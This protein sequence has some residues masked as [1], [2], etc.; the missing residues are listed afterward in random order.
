[1][2]VSAV[3]VRLLA[4]E[5]AWILIYTIPG[6][7]I[8]VSCFAVLLFKENPLPPDFK[9]VSLRTYVSVMKQNSVLICM[10]FQILSGAAIAILTIAYTFFGNRVRV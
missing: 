2:G 7:I 6:L 10:F 4:E 8:S 5:G 9:H 3:A 1:V